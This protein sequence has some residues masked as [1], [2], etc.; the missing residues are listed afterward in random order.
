MPPWT[1]CIAMGG[2][3]AGATQMIR[4]GFKTTAAGWTERVIKYRQSLSQ[5]RV[6][7]AN[8]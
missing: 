1:L 2:F 5:A 4:S 6:A 3:K 8:A 7:E